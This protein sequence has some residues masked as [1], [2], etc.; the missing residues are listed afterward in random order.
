MALVSGGFVGY[1]TVID[2][3]GNSSTLSYR[4]TAADMTA[5]L[6]D[7]STILTALGAVTDANVKS[8]SVAEVFVENALTFPLAGTHVENRAVITVQI[9]NEP[10]KKGTVV[11]PAPDVGIFAASVGPNSN[12]VDI[13]DAA[14]ISYIDI[15]RT[16]GALAKLSD[17]ETVQDVDGIIKGVRTHRKSSNG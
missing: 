13:N 8:Y 5:A 17:G 6:A 11:I 9:D 12:V 2:S 4:L 3:G 14:L 1:V 7:M 15:W 10:L 16:T